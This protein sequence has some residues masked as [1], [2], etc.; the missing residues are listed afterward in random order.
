M[1]SLNLLPPEQKEKIKTSA[2][3]SFWKKFSLNFFIL[4][5]IV[6]IVLFFAKNILLTYKSQLA[7]KSANLERQSQKLNQEIKN[8]NSE[9][10]EIQKIQKNFIKWS[11][12]FIAFNALIPPD[13]RLNYLDIV[14]GVQNAKNKNASAEFTLKLSG[15]AKDRDDLLLL[16]DNLKTSPLFSQVSSPLSN[17]LQ[18]E[19]VDFTFEIKLADSFNQKPWKLTTQKYIC[20]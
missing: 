5:I 1:I 3:Y 16:K 4:F 17:I 14:S 11:D 20:R 7:E 12:F 9:L 6:T 2:T 15:N 10:K 8:I 19:N 18:K 13:I